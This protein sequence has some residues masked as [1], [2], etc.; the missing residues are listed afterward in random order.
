M[1]SSTLPVLWICGASGA[2]KSVTAWSVFEKVAQDGATVGYLDIDQ[3][4]M[5][6]PEAADDPDSYRLKTAA[7]NALIPNYL[8]YGAQVLI[9][10]GI[11]DPESPPDLASHYPH[12]DLTFCLLDTDATTLHERIL[13]RGW[14][15]EDA[16]EAAADAT[17]LA[18]AEF[19]D[20]TIGSAGASIDQVADRVRSLL[21]DLAPR[22]PAAVPPLTPSAAE[23]GL[24]V[25]TGARAVGTSTIG[26]GVARSEW[27]SGATAG[28]ADLDQLSFLRIGD[29]DDA[30]QTALGVANVA[31]LHELFASHG[32]ARLIVSAHLPA[33]A[34][35][36]LVRSAAPKHVVTIVRLRADI[37]TI[38]GH[39]RERTSGS[40]ARLAGDDLTGASPDRQAEV[41]QQACSHQEHLDARADED[42]LVDVS[43]RPVEAVVSEIVEALDHEAG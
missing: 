13:A 32:A 22:V 12:A 8:A 11:V 30:A 27:Q 3:I 16:E 7:L 28:F 29:A 17:A 9:V 41:V 43:R 10:S 40:N 24:V 38:I 5:L 37:E 42:V 26:F 23:A 36:E 15:P 1:S 6:L 39:V 31:A 4:G 14:D 18:Q 20:I 21:P 34:E 35:H 2:G 33:S 25:L 19:V